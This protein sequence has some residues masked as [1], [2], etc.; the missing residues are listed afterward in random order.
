MDAPTAD[1]AQ[2]STQL[3]I[4]GTGPRPETTGITEPAHLRRFINAIED[5]VAAQGPQARWILNCARGFDSWVAQAVVQ[6]G[7]RFDVY[8][9]FP[10]HIVTA[11]W[12][13]KDA[14]F[15]EKVISLAEAVR[16]V[17]GEYASDAYDERDQLSV[18]ESS[19][20]FA[21]WDGRQQGGTF[22][23][24]QHGRQLRRTI[25]ILDP[26]TLQVRRELPLL[27]A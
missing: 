27:R 6:I 16:V 19:R 14:L 12:S 10:A 25:D 1:R 13:R 21:G 20:V 26:I 9:P 8:L 18:Q 17:R 3:V 7:A 11:K 22:R 4:V 5:Y 23:T 24:V 2:A 15:L